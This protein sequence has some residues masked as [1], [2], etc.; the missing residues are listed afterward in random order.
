MR[1]LADP[2][3]RAAAYHGERLALRC[4]STQRS[5]AELVERAKRVGGLLDNLNVKSGERVALWSANSA[6]YIELYSGVPAAG[7]LIVPLNTRWAQAELVDTLKDAGASVLLCDRDPGELADAVKTVVRLD[8]DIS[9]EATKA[10]QLSYEQLLAEA[11]PVDFHNGSPED[12][13]GLFYT[14]G[15]TGRS[16]GVM[17][18]HRNLLANTMNSQVTVPLDGDD[19]YLVVAPLFHA[20]GSN[21]VLQCI[22][23]GV[24]QIIVPAFDPGE[25][26][27]LI[28]SEGCTVTLAVPT[29]VLAMNEAQTSKARDVSSMRLLAHGGSPV[30][31]E[32]VRR[33]A[34]LFTNA[35]LI[36]LYGATEASP[37]LT[38]LRH[39][40]RLVDAARGKSV[41]QAVLDVSLRVETEDG[42]EAEAGEAGEVLASGSNIMAGYWERP[43][44]TAAALSSDGWY[45]TGDV[46][47]LDEEGYLY[48]VDRA[49]D[50]IISGGENV[51]CTEVEDVLFQHEK[52]L[53]ATVFGIPHERWGE[54]VHAVVVARDESLTAE[55]L[56]AFCR[57]TL[58]G[59]KLPSSVEF[60]KGELPK[61]GP[62]K[63]LKHELRAA[64][65]EGYDRQVN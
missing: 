53:E 63:V 46:G 54:S 9:D 2:L 30:A 42:R 19:V 38:G 39:E 49:K 22:S 57:K 3:R 11:E 35:E 60:I 40:E 15:T 5:F 4:G 13:A 27:D 56:I 50:M 36:H 52:V 21:S 59:Y 14:G 45:R 31:M 23:L 32:V 64:Y 26:L 8:V 25:C 1:T 48:I 17:L 28:E 12:L 6:E 51:Y 65:W 7:R 58:A 62:G 47:L 43:D 18:T 29:M 24:P 34:E 44:E 20:A 10:S 55:E 41:G 37:L 61:S 16:K 33:S